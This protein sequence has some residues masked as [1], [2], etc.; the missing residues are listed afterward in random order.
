MEENKA[1]VKQ[2]P[3]KP[4]PL[5]KELI[6]KTDEIK[7]ESPRAR[8]IIFLSYIDELLKKLLI[9][10]LVISPGRGD[11]LFDPGEPMFYFGAR[12]ELAY[13]LGMISSQM[14]HDLDMLRRIRDICAHDHS[15]KSFENDEIKSRVDQIHKDMK[16]CDQLETDVSKKF[17]DICSNIVIELGTEMEN[18]KRFQPRPLEM[19]YQERSE[20][21][22]VINKRSKQA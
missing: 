19:W 16:Y 8:I 7:Q 5:V 11:E 4:S 20:I 13:R 3:I 14:K 15:K 12:I 17:N 6:A 21:L 2:K 1:S 10:K 22:K 18:T 9:A